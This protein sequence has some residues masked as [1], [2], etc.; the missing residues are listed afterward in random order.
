MKYIVYYVLND[1]SVIDSTEHSTLYYALDQLYYW[2][3]NSRIDRCR[4]YKLY[5]GCISTE[6]AEIYNN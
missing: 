1:G 6:I 3:H 2:L 5:Y 4:I